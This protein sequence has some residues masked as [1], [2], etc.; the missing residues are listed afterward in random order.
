MFTYKELINIPYLEIGYRNSI[1]S[2]KYNIGEIDFIKWD[3]VTSPAMKG[4]DM[5]NRP[6]LVI[7][8]IIDNET[9]MQTFFQRHTYNNDLWMGIGKNGYLLK[10]YGGLTENQK[11]LIL[12]IINGKQPTINEHHKPFKHSY[13]GKKVMLYE[14]NKW[15]AAITIQRA[16][17]KCRYDPTFKMCE[18]VLFSNLEKI[19]KEYAEYVLD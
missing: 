13:I 5:Y 17:K 4:V 14:E 18:R 16:W 6:F 15:K 9:I 1:F 12:D 2:N 8:I 3:E 11:K 7:K 10:T 19:N